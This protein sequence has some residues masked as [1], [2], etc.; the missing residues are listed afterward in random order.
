[1]LRHT[2]FIAVC[3]A[4]F[5]QVLAFAPA[6]PRA[7]TFRPASSIPGA[8]P[9]N[10]FVLRMADEETEAVSKIDADGTFYDDEVSAMIWV[11]A[12]FR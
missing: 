7:M 1:M 3:I 5:S 12:T 11:H 8:K 4:L 10:A 6:S 2:L 9:T